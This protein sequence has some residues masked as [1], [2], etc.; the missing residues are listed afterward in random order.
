MSLRR[1]RFVALVASVVALLAP[2][3]ASAAPA[4]IHPGVQTFTQ[5]AQ[6]TSNFIF[7]RGRA[8]FIGQAAHCSGTGSANDTDGCRSKSLPVGTKV[9]VDGARDRGTLAYNSWLTMQR[10]GER[11]AEA[12][13]YNDLALVR[14]S[15]FD[16]GRVD[17]SIPTFG[18]PQGIGAAASGEKVY[19]YGNS[20]LRFGVSQLRPKT[21]RVISRSPGGWSYDVYTATPGVPGDSGSAFLNTRGQALGVL[22]TVAIAPLTGSNGVGSIARELTYARAHGFDGLRLING[23]TPFRPRALG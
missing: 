3:S 2:G 23:T 22:S 6:C 7:K 17:P 18:G 13:A 16:A 20:G 21:G 19:T 5:G 12:C 4:P 1:A 8:T 11:G 14:L 10:V 9:V 15:R